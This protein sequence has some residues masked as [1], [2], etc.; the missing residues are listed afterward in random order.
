[1]RVDSAQPEPWDFVERRKGERRTNPGR[2]ATD[3]AE[4]ENL[5]SDIYEIKQELRMMSKTLQQ[6]AVQEE[7]IRNIQRNTDEFSDIC[8]DLYLRLNT[9][10]GNHNKCH[11]G[12][13]STEV[14]WIKWFVVTIMVLMFGMLFSM[15]GHILNGNGND[16][17]KQS[18]LKSNSSFY[19]DAPYHPP[20]VK[21][22][23]VR[24]DGRDR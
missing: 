5:K 16:I 14:A 4:A 17:P 1:M 19:M 8:K 13:V 15:F 18:K 22:V 10:E 7:R 9:V 2:R 24:D 21:R 12:R 23:C 20:L 3:V 11:I 6:I